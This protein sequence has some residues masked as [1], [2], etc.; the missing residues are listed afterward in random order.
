MWILKEDLETSIFK[1]IKG[2]YWENGDQLF[3]VFTYNQGHL[4]IYC[5]FADLS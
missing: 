2:P 5:G 4:E 1:Y 3:P